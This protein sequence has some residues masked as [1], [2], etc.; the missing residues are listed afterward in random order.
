MTTNAGASEM[1]KAAIGFGKV[2]RDGDD[3][4]A[5]NRLFTPEFRNRLD[6]I[7]PFTP[8]SQFVINQIVKKFILQLETQLADRGVCFELSSSAMAWL[9]HKGYDLQM[10]ARPLSRIIQKHIKNH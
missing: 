1:A 10:G 6:A 9:A 4:E 3:I 8:L 5:I 2:Y 7:I